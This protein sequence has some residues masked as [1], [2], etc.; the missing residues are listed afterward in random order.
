MLGS[1]FGVAIINK[2]GRKLLLIISLL[3]C[4]ICMA[5]I[6][7][8]YYVIR[9]Y[10]KEE[11]VVASWIALVLLV[12]NTLSFMAGLAPVPWVLV[13]ELLPGYYSIL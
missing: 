8:C 4:S 11:A 10:S 12:V 2:A 6:G 13:G 7:G 9:H 5:G 3:V 1:S